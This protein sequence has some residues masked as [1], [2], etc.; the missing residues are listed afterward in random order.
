MYETLD[1]ILLVPTRLLVV[2]VAVVMV[3]RRLHREYPFFFASLVLLT[4][5]T[6][7]LY[8]AHRLGELAYFLSYYVADAIAIPVYLAVIHELFTHLFQPY[9]AIRDL[10]SKVFRVALFAL[11]VFALIAAATAHVGDKYPILA[12]IMALERTFALLRT[13]LILTLFLLA[14]YLGL[15][16][17]HPAFGIAVGSGVASMGSLISYVL[18]AHIGQSAD[19]LDY[20]AR[21]AALCAACIWAAYVFRPEP[22]PKV[23]FVPRHA[24]LEAWNRSLAELLTR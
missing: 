24:D 1:L 6:I 15:A 16:W 5:R 21:G 23:A 22:E 11:L 7:G 8:A 10:G 4:V 17:K 3:R 2:A 14:W 9:E 18:R 19:V 12:G 13:G 20:G